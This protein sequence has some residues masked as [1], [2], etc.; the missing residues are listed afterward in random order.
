[1]DKGYDSEEIHELIQDTFN[2]CSIP[3][4]NQETD[5]RI[6]SKTPRSSVR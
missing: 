1:M 2:A 5:F 3:D 4:Q 6:L